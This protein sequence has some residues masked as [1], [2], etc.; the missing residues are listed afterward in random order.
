MQGWSNSSS[1]FKI[2][3]L[4]L[5]HSQSLFVVFQS[6]PFWL[7]NKLGLYSDTLC[8]LSFYLNININ[9]AHFLRF[10]LTFL[11]VLRLKR[12]QKSTDNTNFTNRKW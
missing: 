2:L 9:F 11:L 12:S 1:L 6:K 10:K 7:W 4:N 3:I 8:N 5:Y